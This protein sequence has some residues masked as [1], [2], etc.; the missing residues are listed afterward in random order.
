MNPF[1]NTHIHSAINNTLTSSEIKKLEKMQKKSYEFIESYHDFFNSVNPEAKLTVVLKINEMDKINI[2]S[3]KLVNFV[4]KHL[5]EKSMEAIKKLYSEFGYMIEK[6]KLDENDLNMLMEGTPDAH[7]AYSQKYCP[8]KKIRL[9]KLAKMKNQLTNAGKGILPKD[10]KKNIHKHLLTVESF[11]TAI[12][13]GAIGSPNKLGPSWVKRS[14]EDLPSQNLL[15]FIQD[16]KDKKFIVESLGEK[17]FLS[18]GKEDL[19]SNRSFNKSKIDIKTAGLSK[20]KKIEK[21]ILNTS[22]QKLGIYIPKGTQESIKGVTKEGLDERYFT[23]DSY[24][25]LGFEQ[26]VSMRAH[27]SGS[28]PLSLAAI[29]FLCSGRNSDELSD[30]HLAVYAGL[31]LLTYEVGDYHSPAE[32]TAGF[33][34]FHQENKKQGIYYS[35]TGNQGDQYL[36]Q[37]SPKNFL[38]ISIGL[39]SNLVEDKQLDVYNEL[40]Q[41]VLENVKGGVGLKIDNKKE[42][43]KKQTFEKI[44]SKVFSGLSSVISTFKK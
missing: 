41:N 33:C 30:E 7:F 1:D 38:A 25:G 13:Y 18:R 28:A 23:I 40:A 4:I 36:S 16:F 29:Q 24:V 2:L 12:G 27:T 15:N 5:S 32:T 31:L 17:Q 10:F 11:S 8:D 42:S 20:D 43:I 37:V 3:R 19:I 6:Y 9:K 21:P 34:H 39:M 35:N 26:G 44:I 14:E 22:E